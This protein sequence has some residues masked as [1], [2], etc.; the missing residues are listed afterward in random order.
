MSYQEI[1]TPEE[2]D[3]NLERKRELI[4]L[5]ASKEAVLVVGA[6]SSVRVGYVS[7]RELLGQ[8]DDLASKCGDGFPKDDEKRENDPIEYAA[9]IKSHMEVSG[10][11]E[12]Y[13]A[14]LF[15]LFKSRNPQYTQFHKTLISLPF[16]GILT[17]NYDPVLEAAL[18]D[19]EPEFGYDNSLVVGGS[20][21]SLV[22][23]F[24]MAMNND[25]RFH[26][27]VAHLH[28]KFDSPENIVLGRDDYFSAYGIEL[29]DKD[30]DRSRQISWTLH[31]KLLWSILAT[32]RVMFVGFGLEDPYFNWILESVSADLWKWDKAIHF[33]VASISLSNADD[34]K[35]KAERLKSEFGVGTVFYE[36]VDNTHSSLDHFVAEIAMECGVDIQ[37]VTVPEDPSVVLDQD[38][39][40]KPTRVE[41]N[42]TDT[43]EWVDQTNKR[44][45]R[46]ID[47]EN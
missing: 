30:G 13:N 19:C 37:P 26:R 8:L 25:Q 31:R 32:R 18:S 28:G 33:A 5:V 15:E 22:H 45:L 10:T 47:D 4:Q 9:Q 40:E 1:F 16:R 14:R 7:W 36:L 11:I 29:N 17:T 44:M 27:R 2:R 3:K 39:R 23:E 42:A 21:P 34:L 6:G 24:L 12:R 38:Y 20:A 35:A 46:Q 43:L 41:S